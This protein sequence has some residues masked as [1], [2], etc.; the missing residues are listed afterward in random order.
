M[1]NGG[2]KLLTAVN[3]NVAFQTLSCGIKKVSK[4][5]NLIF[6]KQGYFTINGKAATE[7]EITRTNYVATGS[8]YYGN[9]WSMKTASALKKGSTGRIAQ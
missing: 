3:N 7:L 8:I 1:N 6:N 4:Y 2:Y 9:E 5:D